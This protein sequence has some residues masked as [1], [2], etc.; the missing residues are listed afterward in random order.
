MTPGRWTDEALSP[1]CRAHRFGD[2]HGRPDAATAPIRPTNRGLLRP[3]VRSSSCSLWLDWPS[4]NPYSTCS[5]WPRRFFVFLDASRGDIALFAVLVTALPTAVLWSIEQIVSIVGERTRRVVHLSLVGLL[6]L[7]LGLGSL[8]QAEVGF[9]PSA[10]PFGGGIRSLGGHCFRPMEGSAHVGAL[11]RRCSDHLS[12][13][14]FPNR[15]SDFRSIEFPGCCQC[16]DWSSR[17][18]EDRRLRLERVAIADHSQQGWA[19]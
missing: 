17:R 12:R 9:R 7:L 5:A 19:H 13:R 6:V 3:L 10:S 15:E 16:L 11:P 8:K 4:L 1:A 14:S 2:G 18:S